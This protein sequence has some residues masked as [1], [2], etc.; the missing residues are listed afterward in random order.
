MDDYREQDWY[1]RFK[2]F[3]DQNRLF[4]KEK[5][6]AV[7]VRLTPILRDA[8]V[9]KVGW[10]PSYLLHILKP[11]EKSRVNAPSRI[12]KDAVMRAT[13]KPRVRK[14]KPRLYTPGTREQ[15]NLISSRLPAHRR[16]EILL[17]AAEEL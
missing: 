14:D 16:L 3:I 4:E 1:I 11:T 12:F 6:H 10:T 7:C 15:I 5:D 8:A 9:T 13:T 17:S 2:R